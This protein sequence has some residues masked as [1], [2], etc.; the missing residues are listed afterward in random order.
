MSQSSPLYLND[1]RGG[2]GGGGGGGR[3][4]G[5]TISRETKGAARAVEPSAVPRPKSLKNSNGPTWS[6]RR[7]CLFENLTLTNP[8]LAGLACT[9]CHLFQDSSMSLCIDSNSQ[10]SRHLCAGHSNNK[11]TH[12]TA[13]PLLGDRVFLFLLIPQM[14]TIR[15]S[16]AYLAF[17]T[18][19]IVL[20]LTHALTPS[21]WISR[22]CVCIHPRSCKRFGALIHGVQGFI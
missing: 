20:F 17:T 10:T 2:G 9:W 3:G 15:V 11:H 13:L 7:P 1:T 18:T 22:S 4:G 8:C 12:A 16:S 21:R 19:R 6:A 5:G 14:S